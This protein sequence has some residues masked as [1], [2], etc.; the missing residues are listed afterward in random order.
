V[1]KTNADS[2]LTIVTS[3][4]DSLVETIVKK[5]ADS[6]EIDLG[7]AWTDCYLEGG[8]EYQRPAEAL[9]RVFNLH[10]SLTWVMC[11]NCG[12]LYSNQQG[13]IFALGFYSPCPENTC[14]CGYCPL[15]PVIVAPSYSWPEPFRAIQDVWRAAENNLREADEWIFVGYSLPPE[16]LGIRSLLLKAYAGHPD[17]KKPIIRVFIGESRKEEIGN[18]YK[19]LFPETIVSSKGL[20]GLLEEEG[21]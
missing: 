3:N 21:A 5:E 12:R 1:R 20:E 13:P 17:G 16:D 7:V 19:L 10:G 15:R 8:V 18:F 4:Y 2:F 9:Y 11:S 6:K 14:E